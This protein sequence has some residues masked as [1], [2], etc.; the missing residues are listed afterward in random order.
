M[1]AG[2]II[3]III[4][5]SLALFIIGMGIWSKYITYKE[6]KE[7]R[8]MLSTLNNSYLSNYTKFLEKM[9]KRAEARLKELKDKEES[10]KCK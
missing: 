2:D 7:H 10:K 8:K 3:T 5:C 1:V 4:V 9:H 6:E